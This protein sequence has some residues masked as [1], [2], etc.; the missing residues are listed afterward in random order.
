MFYPILEYP[1]LEYPISQ[2]ITKQEKVVTVHNKETRMD[3]VLVG[4]MGS[5]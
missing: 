1:I 2:R 3:P 5:V 4:P